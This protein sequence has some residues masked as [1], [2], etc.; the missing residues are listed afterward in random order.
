MIT[1]RW[2]FSQK[3]KN[4][5]Q[6]VNMKIISCRN[7]FRINLMEFK[8]KCH[9]NHKKLAV[10]NFSLFFFQNF[11][12][13]FAFN[14]LPLFLVLRKLNETIISIS[15][16]EENRLFPRHDCRLLR[17]Y[18]REM[19]YFNWAAL[20]Y[21]QITYSCVPNAHPNWVFRQFSIEDLFKFKAFIRVF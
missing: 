5:L 4:D 18:A 7:I 17:I 8:E 9:I 10:Q 6:T 20:K 19:R 3:S 16:R 15:S 1:N 11:Q 13:T 14:C 21:T 2:I 12:E